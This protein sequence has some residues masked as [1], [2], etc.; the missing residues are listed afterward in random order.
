MTA[1]IVLQHKHLHFMLESYHLRFEHA[2]RRWQEVSRPW[3]D[4]TCW[5]WFQCLTITLFSLTTAG[6][7]LTFTICPQ[8]W[9]GIAVIASFMPLFLWCVLIAISLSA[10]Q[11]SFGTSPC[12]CQRTFK[13]F[14]GCVLGLSFCMRCNRAALQDQQQQFLPEELKELFS[15]MGCERAEKNDPFAVPQELHDL[16]ETLIKFTQ[17][18]QQLALELPSILNESLP[19]LPIELHGLIE[20]F[21]LLS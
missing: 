18:H 17:Y 7:T 16:K 21:I 14:W 19:S 10:F 1:M 8:R 3:R 12:C 11:P 5:G 2:S 15:D 6:F 20:G 9:R 4:Q 13:C